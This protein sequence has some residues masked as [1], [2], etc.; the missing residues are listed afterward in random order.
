MEESLTESTVNDAAS[1][2]EPTA[3]SNINTEA[4]N[5]QEAISNEEANAVTAQN[6]KSDDDGLSRFAKSQGFDPDNLTDGERRALKIAHDNQKAYRNNK[7]SK[8][9]EVHKTFNDESVSN[10]DIDSFK[11]EFNQ[12]KYEQKT[13]KFWADENKDKNLESEMVRILNEKKEQFGTEYAKNLSNDLDA[14]YDLAKAQS[15]NT[16]NEQ[17]I[18]QEERDSINRM[19]NASAAVSH[20]STTNSDSGKI[21]ITSDWI[22]NEYNSNNPEHRALVD[23]YFQNNK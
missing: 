4:D 7:S 15:S 21:K 13:S 12:F 23:A 5:N 9:D 1:Q 22:R 16:N 2:V 14:L 10:N 18:R 20:A 8:I 19:L 11:K 3:Q 6:N 17:Q